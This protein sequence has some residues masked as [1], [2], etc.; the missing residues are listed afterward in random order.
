MPPGFRDAYR[1]WT[2]AGWNALT[3]PESYGGQGLPVL[4]NSG[5]VEMWNAAS[6]A[7]GVGPLLTRGG[8]EALAGH[9]S[10]ERKSRYVDRIVSGEWTATMSR[11]EPQAGSDLGALR[12]RAERA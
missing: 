9:G 4:L 12:T 7:F 3:G 8:I 5:C 1:A 6:L 10:E 2:E 11:T